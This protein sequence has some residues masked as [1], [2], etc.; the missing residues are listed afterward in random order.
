[1]VKKM[2]FSSKIKCYHTKLIKNFSFCIF[3][4]S[5]SPI[6]IFIE[7]SLKEKNFDTS[8]D[9]PLY[10]DEPDRIGGIDLLQIVPGVTPPSRL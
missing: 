5:T 7:I 9:G 10:N 4:L 1:M 6:V 3:L 8:I 2:L